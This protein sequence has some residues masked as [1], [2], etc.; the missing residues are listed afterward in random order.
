MG[1]MSM[2]II[3]K[4]VWC[5]FCGGIVSRERRKEPKKHL[6]DWYGSET[7]MDYHELCW[8]YAI[9]VVP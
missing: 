2:K 3:T 9:E 7:I 4:T 1:K 5:R 6:R 8:A